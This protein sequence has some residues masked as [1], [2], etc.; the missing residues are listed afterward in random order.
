MSIKTRRFLVTGC[1][2]YIGSHMCWALR[3]AYKDEAIIFGL[4]ITPLDDS[5]HYLLDGFFQQDLASMKFYDHYLAGGAKKLDFDCIFH[6]AAKSI[7]PEGEEYPIL[8]YHNNVV[9]AMNVMNIAMLHNT[10]NLILS[11]TCAVYGNPMYSPIDENHIK[12]PLSVYGKSKS[13]IEDILWDIRNK[14]NIG[15]LR[16]FN[17]AG[18]NVKSN[19]H[20]RHNP[21]TH[22]IPLLVQNDSIE[23]YGTDYDTT[24]GTAIRDY[25]H[26]EDLCN[27]HIY[28]Y[29]YM[30]KNNESLICNLGT[31]K[32]H[33]VLQVI[34]AV[35]R[36]FGKKIEVIEKSRRPGDASWLVSDVTRMK[37]VLRFHPK[38]DMMDIVESMKE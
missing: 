25:I 31:G 7:V 38:Y 29:D 14:I 21:E 24:D 16:Y 22:L 27:A 28:A 15:I 10:K 26:V 4:D 5:V 8:Y 20:E 30:T 6:F 36:T 1:N 19:L 2:G 32:G 3:N 34:N 23:L 13:H 33:S 11:S 37:E 35:R 17:A 12:N 9:S 18:R